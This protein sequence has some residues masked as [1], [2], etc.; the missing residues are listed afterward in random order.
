MSNS[1]PTIPTPPAHHQNILRQPIVEQAPPRPTVAGPPKPVFSN[2]QNDF[3]PNVQHV[4]PN[5]GG[6]GPS[7]I[8]TTSGPALSQ[9][10]LAKQIPVRRPDATKP[11][12]LARPL[13]VQSGG[14]SK[15]NDT[16]PKALPPKEN[17]TVDEI[18]ANRTS[19][20]K[21]SPAILH[22]PKAK[23]TSPKQQSPAILAGKPRSSDEAAVA[24]A[25]P[26]ILTPPPPPVDMPGPPLSQYSSPAPSVFKEGV[27]PE[28]V[29]NLRNQRVSPGPALEP[30]PL[31][32]ADPSEA[33]GNILLT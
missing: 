4:T 20:K 10:L 25:D 1:G 9:P 26:I 28:V 17:R 7:K 31:T 16:G 29:I 18:Q 5:L 32:Y 24:P 8:P 33:G 21:Q 22:P 6:F 11:A 15:A 14:A 2:A 30:T 27:V 13:P 3:R 12:P 19:P 23:Q